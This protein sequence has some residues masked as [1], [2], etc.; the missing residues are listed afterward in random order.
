MLGK[1]NSQKIEQY[2]ILLEYLSS[3]LSA[4][5][6]LEACLT[7][8]YSH[9]RNELGYKSALSKSLKN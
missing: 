3:R 8:A 4:G 5:Y 2:R 9:L 7:D 6:T 1:Q